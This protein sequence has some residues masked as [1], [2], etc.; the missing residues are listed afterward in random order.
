MEDGSLKGGLYGA[1]CEYLADKAPGVLVTGIG[2]PDRFITH[3][4][5]AAQRRECG[6][7]AEGISEK[8]QEIL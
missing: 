6:I 5:Q 8:I 3:D 7:D 2:A 4:T 1:V